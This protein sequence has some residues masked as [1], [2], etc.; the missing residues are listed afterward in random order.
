MQCPKCKFQNIDGARFCGKCGSKLENICPNCKYKN[1][2]NYEYCSEC[3]QTLKTVRPE[4]IPSLSEKET[5]AK[6]TI[7]D[8]ERKHVTVM[9]SDLSGYTAMTEKPFS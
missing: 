6:P 4:S 7:T 5:P 2:I 8:Q 9:F 3:G 1:P